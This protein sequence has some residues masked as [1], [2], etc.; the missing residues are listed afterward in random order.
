[1]GIVDI[2][3]YVLSFSMSEPAV[4]GISQL[5]PFLQKLNFTSVQ[6]V[7]T[8]EGTYTPNNDYLYLWKDIPAPNAPNFIFLQTDGLLALSITSGSL[9]MMNAA[10]INKMFNLLLPPSNLYAVDNIYI[11]GRALT[12]MPMA[13][14]V[15]V[16]YFCLMAQATF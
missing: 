8:K 11:E 9:V 10:P 13:P 14:G 1:M 5:I 7:L 3:S 4:N 12:P 6:N 15:P 2:K 16:N